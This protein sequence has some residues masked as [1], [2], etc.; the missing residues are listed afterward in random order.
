MGERVLAREHP[1]QA[2]GPPPVSP[3][4]KGPRLER[5]KKKR[6]ARRPPAFSG[7][8][9][10]K[11]PARQWNYF[12]PKAS[13][14]MATT[15]SFDARIAFILPRVMGSTEAMKYSALLICPS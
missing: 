3:G 13:S 15:A 6:K 2:V 1:K 12:P 14:E 10:R 5:P 9:W 4:S 8:A 7:M 11:A